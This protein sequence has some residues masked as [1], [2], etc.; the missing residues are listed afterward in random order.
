MM[1]IDNGPI[2]PGAGIGNVRLG[3]SREELL[4]IIGEDFQERSLETGS[5]I[6]IENANIWIADDGKVDQIGVEK[7]FG[8]KYEEVIGL[9]ST[10]Q[11]V[12]QYIGDYVEVYDTYELKG[13]KGICFELE[14]IDEWNEL[15]APIDHIYVFRV[16]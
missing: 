6:T 14:D 10:L 2:I 8:G 4:K 7:E 5:I 12:R 11:D 15:K 1:K 16:E 3:I 13:V 9:G